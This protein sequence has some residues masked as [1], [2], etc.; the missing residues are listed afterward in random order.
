MTFFAAFIFVPQTLKMI[1]HILVSPDGHGHMVTAVTCDHHDER[2]QDAQEPLQ[3]N[4][5][6]PQQDKE[7]L[8]EI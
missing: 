7:A 2:K 1:E 4:K 6:P 3:Q 5:Q 8:Y